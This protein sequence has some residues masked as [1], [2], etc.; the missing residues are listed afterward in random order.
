MAVVSGDGLNTAEVTSI[1]TGQKGIA[2]GIASLD[3]SAK[4]PSAQLPDISISQTYVVASEAA[5]LALTAQ[6]GD[7]A[8]RTDESKTYIQNGGSAGT[9]ADWTELLSP[10]DA[11][12]SVNGYTGTVVLVAD[13][14]DLGTDDS[15]RFTKVTAGES[16]SVTINGSAVTTQFDSNVDTQAITSANTHSDTATNG[17]T[18]YNIRSRGTNSTPT[19]V[20]DGDLLASYAA[21][22][23]DGTDYAS[24][25]SIDFEVDGTPG[26]NDMPARV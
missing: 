26:N 1:I 22:G 14:L 5:Q 15:V 19:V 24:A 8:V 9:M 25:G 17:S 4:I 7:V 11:V 23:H 16:D 3:G 13:D 6:E 20:Q 2:N 21:A 10:T 12:Q 18:Y